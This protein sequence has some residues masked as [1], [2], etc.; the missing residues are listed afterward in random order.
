MKIFWR[1]LCA[2]SL[3]VLFVAGFSF[4]SDLTGSNFLQPSKHVN[5]VELAWT[6]VAVIGLIISSRQVMAHTKKMK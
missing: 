2:I 3:I 5:G 1:V 4:I 6:I